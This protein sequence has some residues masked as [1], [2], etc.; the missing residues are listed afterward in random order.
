MVFHIMPL[1][2]SGTGGSRRDKYQHFK[3]IEKEMKMK[4]LWDKFSSVG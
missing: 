2:F 1:D 4:E 3:F